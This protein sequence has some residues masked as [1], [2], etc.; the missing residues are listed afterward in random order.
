MKPLPAAILLASALPAL[1]QTPPAKTAEDD[2]L[3]FVNTPVS[4]ASTKAATVFTAPSTVSVIDRD[5]IERY[6]F[7]SL[8]EAIETLSGV[9]LTQPLWNRNLP[10]IRGVLQ[11]SYANRVLM[12]VNGVASWN[13][14]TGDLFLSRID[15]EDVER[16]E[17]LKGPASVLYGTNA[18]AGAINV[19]LRKDEKTT[20][21][22]HSGWQDA[23]GYRIG[24]SHTEKMG[25]W[26]LFLSANGQHD[27]TKTRTMT[28]AEQTSEPDGIYSSYVFAEQFHAKNANLLLE[29]YG[30]VIQAN[31]FHEESP[32]FGAANRYTYGG[33]TQ[34]ENNGHFLHVGYQFKPIQALTLKYA[35]TYDAG[36]KQSPVSLTDRSFF[37]APDTVIMNIGLRQRGNRTA[38][39]VSGAWD[40]NPN[41]NLEL[42]ATTEKRINEYYQQYDNR[43]GQ[44]LGTS[45]LGL[46]GESNL[47]DVTLKEDS[48][49]GQVG[50]T[51]SAWN[52]VLGARRTK[53]E[54]FG[55]NTSSRLTVVYALN[56]TSSVKFIYGQSFRAPSFLESRIRFG[57][58]WGNQDLKPETSDSFE[59][60]YVGAFGNFFIQA[61]AFQTTFEDKAYRSATWGTISVP[62][63]TTVG[64]RRYYQNAPEFRARGLEIEMKYQNPK[65]VN[66][67]L[68]LDYISGNNGDEILDIVGTTPVLVGYNYKMV[69]KF[70]ASGGVN[71]SLWGFTGAM[72]VNYQ[73]GNDGPRGP[74]D[75]TGKAWETIPA[76]TSVDLTLSYAHSIGRF[77]FRHTGAIKN[78]RD[79]ERWSPEA[80]RRNTN[81]LP[82]MEGRKAI[83]TL[84]VSF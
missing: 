77:H 30:L 27:V 58:V 11:E 71:K 56:P 22:A 5:S 3:D 66:A 81:R 29:G 63:G 13:T 8:A 74:V 73:A 42:G 70:S 69:P 36:W 35:G 24:A 50:F 83:Y 43:T 45:T 48:L 44:T 67:F 31:G 61:I 78:A 6:G 76:W 20:T 25:T 53:N 10:T 60:S 14:L 55:T 46:N 16:I 57:S 7:L 15:I 65:L 68:N 38:H 34:W 32:W 37:P 52:L 47:K 51:A 2:F 84:G 54:Q 41:W 33:G 17:V 12:L 59:L 40:I 18:Y 49:Y 72:L 75:Y 80:T 21:R 1:G 39:A 9:Y 62:V 26:S 64:A 19:V 4:V 79:E 28:V 23:D 82:F